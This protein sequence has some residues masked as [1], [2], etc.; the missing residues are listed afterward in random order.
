M[1]FDACGPGQLG[2]RFEVQSGRAIRVRGRPNQFAR[3]PNVLLRGELGRSTWSRNWRVARVISTFTLCQY[4][5]ALSQI[6]KGIQVSFV[7]IVFASVAAVSNI[8]RPICRA[9]GWA[10][11]PR[12]CQ[13]RQ[14]G[15]RNRSSLESAWHPPCRRG[16]RRVD[17]ALRPDGRG[18]KPFLSVLVDRRQLQVHARAARF[19]RS[20]ATSGHSGCD[21]S[22]ITRAVHAPEQEAAFAR[23]KYRGTFIQGARSRGSQ[24]RRGGDDGTRSLAVADRNSDPDHP[25]DLAVWRPSRVKCALTSSQRAGNLRT[26]GFALFVYA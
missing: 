3:N 23:P 10:G 2:P 9:S 1:P 24:N 18:G 15:R 12:V 11:V 26:A 21:G 25:A 5:H 22:D 14:P 4:E 20:S 8:G 13:G 19:K 7:H 6:N 16:L 17:L